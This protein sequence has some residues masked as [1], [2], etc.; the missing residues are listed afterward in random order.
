MSIIK[1]TFFGGAEKKAAKAQQKGIESGIAATQA[2][3]RRA[4]QQALPLFSAAQQNAGL[5]FQGALDVFGQSLPAQTSAFQ[6]GNM[7]AQQQLLAGLPQIQNALLGNQIDFSQLQ[8]TQVQTPDLGFFQQQLP[9]FVNPFAPSTNQQMGQGG[10]PPNDGFA[11]PNI[12]HNTG[13]SFGGF[14]SALLRRLN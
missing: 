11:G 12:N 10:L 9:Q 5:G 4:E 8:P 7:G 13:S 2:A 3:T 14:N 6:Q 1:D